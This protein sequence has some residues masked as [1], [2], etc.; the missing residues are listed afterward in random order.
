M[1]GL[2]AFSAAVNIVSLIDI[3]VKVFKR[4]N[5]FR[6]DSIALPKALRPV[7]KELPV[8]IETLRLT[9]RARNAH[10][11]E[12]NSWHALQPLIEE[13]FEQIN[14]VNDLV[15]KALPKQ[16]DS[17]IIKSWK[18]LVSFRYD[19]EIKEAI[20]VVRELQQTLTHQGVAAARN[21][22]TLPPE[23]SRPSLVNLP[24]PRDEDFV[25][26][27]A[28]AEIISQTHRPDPISRLALVGT[29]G[30]G[31]SQIAIEYAYQ[32]RKKSP[33][34]WVFWVHAGSTTKLEEGY[35]AIAR[36]VGLEDW[37]QKET[38]IFRAVYDWLSNERNGSWI[39][40]L[41]NA[42][43]LNVF[44]AP[45]PHRNT[46]A[47]E[48]PLSES[49]GPQIR[50]FLPSSP[51]GSILITSRVKDVAFELTGSWKYL[52]LD[53]M[54]E[55]EATQLLKR[56]LRG[57]H[58]EDEMLELVKILDC[59]PLAISQAAAYIGR[60]SPRVTVVSYSQM[61]K[62][63][64]TKLLEENAYEARRD[65]ERSNSIVATLQ[66]SLQYV[67]QNEPSA[68]RLLS[69]ICL[70]DR[71][72][73]P[74]CLLEGKYG[75]Q[76]EENKDQM[77]QSKVPDTSWWKRRKRRKRKVKKVEKQTPKRDFTQDW[78]VLNSFSFIKTNHTGDSF[79]M[80]RLIQ[81]TIKRWNDSNGESMY[82][83][84]RFILIVAKHYPEP[85]PQNWNYCEVLFPNAVQIEA[86]R[87]SN[88]EVR[89]YRAALMYRLAEHASSMRNGAMAERLSK[90]ALD[91]V[92]IA[93]GGMETALTLRY[94]ELYGRTLRAV[95]KYD[96]AEPLCRNILEL[97]TKILGPLHADTIT[98][99]GSLA[100]VLERRGKREESRAMYKQ[101]AE[102]NKATSGGDFMWTF[103]H[104]D[105]IAACLR[106]EDYPGAEDIL[107][108]VYDVGKR[109]HGA[110]DDYAIMVT[111]TLAV[112]LKMQER[113]PEAEVLYRQL[114]TEKERVASR[115]DP[116]AS[117]NLAEML[118]RRGK[119]EEAE[120]LYRRA[121]QYYT[122]TDD[123]ESEGALEA[124][125][126]LGEML[127]MRGAFD[128]A[129]D[130]SRHVLEKRRDTSDREIH[131]DPWVA[132]HTLAVILDRRRQFEEALEHYKAAYEGFVQVGG[133]NYVDT[134]AYFKDLVE[135]K[136]KITS[137]SN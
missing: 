121:F 115:V 32:T 30:V 58:N 86:Y 102:A 91:E 123:V 88:K 23:P 128:E 78:A 12:D 40:I 109:T 118:K 36:A 126:D 108:D 107:R 46:L 112:V 68:A 81:L 33:D 56:R 38:D 60:L 99:M 75:E 120:H 69:L 136:E 51:T 129:E 63:N 39:M 113:Y 50:S 71:Q 103:G 127:A 18:G 134:R 16:S 5:E 10:Q 57:T 14:T 79:S 22:S 114:L 53:V 24:Y 125:A 135:M 131:R 117:S 92:K 41:D 87:P 45:A 20:S 28:L 54:N 130:L 90:N 49:T 6:N 11:I 25:E 31:K 67:R 74:D 111:G 37:E 7:K 82:W 100:A 110:W 97:R 116:V 17:G 48:E 9:K 61:A 66:I 4:I 101:F 42:D 105:R 47:R 80:H 3:S 104:H 13:C 21:K 1:S 89:A 77:T 106:R 72:W 84:E 76:W 35:R 93:T 70:F 95:D 94:A 59:M 43:D 26:R 64:I 44:T 34:T 137:V 19:D 62:E 124:M 83:I 98:S 52:E 96:E 73:I 8:F 122:D 119:N 29:G 65:P 27:A 133:E 132:H 15:E 85:G 2:E 55:G